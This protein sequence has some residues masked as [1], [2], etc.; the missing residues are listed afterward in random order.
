[1]PVRLR[2]LSDNRGIHSFQSH[3]RTVELVQ[4]EKRTST[5]KDVQEVFRAMQHNPIAAY[6]QDC[7]FHERLMLASLVKCM[8]REGVEEIKWGE[9][10]FHE[11]S[12]AIFFNGMTFFFFYR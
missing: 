4:S 1:M 5:I 6:L 12:M 7:S 9:V 10:S 11:T 8:K 3:R 2:F